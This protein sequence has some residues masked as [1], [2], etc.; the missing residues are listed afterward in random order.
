MRKFF[1]GLV[2]GLVVVGVADMG[3]AFLWFGGGG[4]GGK[5]RSAGSPSLNA[6]SLFNFNQLGAGPNACDKNSNNCVSDSLGDSLYFSGLGSNLFGGNHDGGGFVGN[7]EGG[8]P[9]FN[10]FD[11]DSNSIGKSHALSNRI[12]KLVSA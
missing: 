9:I 7:H 1:L 6:A 5:H 8:S 2:C 12:S 10:Y 11:I 3:H 4:G